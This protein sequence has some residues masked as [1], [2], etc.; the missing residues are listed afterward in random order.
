MSLK[1]RFWDQGYEAIIVNGDIL[2]PKQCFEITGEQKLVHSY[3]EELSKYQLND[4]GF[5]YNISTGSN[6]N[7]I[8]K[9][10]DAT[11]N[12]FFCTNEFGSM[13]EADFKEKFYTPF[14]GKFF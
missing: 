11:V 7:P 6:L 5:I 14:I 13:A 3:I 12:L 8:T 1:Y 4:V 2:E 9:F 10:T